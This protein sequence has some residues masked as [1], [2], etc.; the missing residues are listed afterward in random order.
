MYQPLIDA[1]NGPQPPQRRAIPVRE[2]RIDP[3]F[4]PPDW[5]VA[6]IE[7]NLDNL[8]RLDE[9]FMTESTVLVIERADGTPWVY[10]DIPSVTALQRARP[11][12]VVPCAVYRDPTQ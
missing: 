4:R 2:L 7:A 1:L 10:D 12:A 11:D 8:R 6:V 5:H 3:A 9:E